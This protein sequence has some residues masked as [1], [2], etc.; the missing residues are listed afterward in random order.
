MDKHS[1]RY[2]EEGEI[3]SNNDTKKSRKG[4]QFHLVMKD[5]KQQ[6]FDSDY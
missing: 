2:S 4:N 5:Y 1:R 6:K 3:S